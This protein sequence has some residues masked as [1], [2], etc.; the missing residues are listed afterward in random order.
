MDK[1]LNLVNK[2]MTDDEIADLLVSRHGVPCDI[3]L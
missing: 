2:G 1:V 3:P